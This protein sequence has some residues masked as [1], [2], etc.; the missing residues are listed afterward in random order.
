MNSELFFPINISFSRLRFVRFLEFLP[1]FRLVGLGIGWYGYGV[2]V[3]SPGCPVAAVAGGREREQV[4]SAWDEEPYELL[5][6]GKIRYIDEQDVVT[7]LDPPKE[8]IPL[9]PASYNPAAYLW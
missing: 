7:F 3:R 9:D 1:P 4:S 8:L 5:S 6:N 2:Y